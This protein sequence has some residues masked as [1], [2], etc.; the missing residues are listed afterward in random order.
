MF[1]GET[2]FTVKT[3]NV[4]YILTI[5]GELATA[6]SDFQWGKEGQPV[7]D[8]GA[9]RWNPHLAVF[10]FFQCS[11]RQRQDNFGEGVPFWKG[12]KKEEGRGLLP[13]SLETLVHLSV[14][15]CLRLGI[16]YLK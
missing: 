6:L 3:D 5:G 2:S 10:N 4:L 8:L 12:K 14:A 11:T 1:L 15:R 9:R 13:W 7:T 16:K